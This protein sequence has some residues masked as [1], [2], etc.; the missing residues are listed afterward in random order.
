M[1]AAARR[2][3]AIARLWIA[4]CLASL[5]SAT[6]ADAFELVTKEESALPAGPPPALQMRGSPARRP[7]IVVVSPPP[8]AGLM[9]SPV[10][11]KLQFQGHGGAQIDPSSVVVTYLKEP[12]IDITQRIMP[13]ITANGI[14]V[15]QAEVPPG[16]HQFWVEVK[17]QTGHVGGAE[18]DFQ[19]AK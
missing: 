11:L 10:E 9:H 2:T 16:K 6:A 17:D 7:K 4:A 14:D 15:A 13:F 19:V 18:I 8:G 12:A 1:A 5:C 3:P